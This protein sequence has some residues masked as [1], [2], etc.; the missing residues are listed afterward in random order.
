MYTNI[1]VALFSKIYKYI[2]FEGYEF[3]FRKLGRFY[4]IKYLPAFK[5]MDDGFIKTNKPVNFPATFKLRRETG[6]NK[7]YVYFD[8]EETGGYSVKVIWDKSHTIFPNMTFF[9]FKLDCI[10][11]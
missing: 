1:L 2:I 8:N 7:R 9:T 10:F 11:C 3:V 5:E 4:A 6:D